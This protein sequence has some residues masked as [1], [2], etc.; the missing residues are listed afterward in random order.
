MK[1][2]KRQLRQIIREEYTRLKLRKMINEGGYFDEKHDS[3][4]SGCV[5]YVAPSAISSRRLSIVD[6]D[7]VMHLHD[8]EAA[9]PNLVRHIEARMM[10]YRDRLQGKFGATS[11]TEDIAR[12]LEDFVSQLCQRVC[13]K[14]CRVV[15]K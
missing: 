12:D 6:G 8:L 11:G 1:I 4:G 7:K 13:G 3:S 14:P 15:F 9:E 2:S 5:A 10:D